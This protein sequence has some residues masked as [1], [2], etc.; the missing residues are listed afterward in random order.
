[1]THPINKLMHDLYAGLAVAEHRGDVARYLPDL[2]RLERLLAEAAQDSSTLQGFDPDGINNGYR[3]DGYVWCR[4]VGRW[5][6]PESCGE[7]C[8]RNC[9]QEPWPDEHT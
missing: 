6:S 7:Y 2:Y 1:M 4:E 5:R 9:G 3:A 8:G